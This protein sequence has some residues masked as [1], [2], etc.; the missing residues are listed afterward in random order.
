MGRHRRWDEDADRR[1]IE[2][3][4]ARQLTIRQIAAGLGRS[5]SA[6]QERLKRL[7]RDGR[8][9]ERGPIHEGP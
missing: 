4:E 8:V 6:V 1:L 7:R 9:S 5:S 2:N 3:F